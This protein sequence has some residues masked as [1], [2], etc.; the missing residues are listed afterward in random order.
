LT[1]AGRLAALAPPSP[2]LSSEIWM[3]GL[4]S[5]PRPPLRPLSPASLAPLSLP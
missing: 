5:A 2:S 3:V 1:P 4:R